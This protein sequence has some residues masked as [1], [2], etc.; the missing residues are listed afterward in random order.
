MQETETTGDELTAT[1]L[2][3]A[4]GF[5]GDQIEA[6]DPD[7][8]GELAGDQAQDFELEA[9]E[10]ASEALDPA[11]GATVEAL[12]QT[13]QSNGGA[14]SRATRGGRKQ[15]NRG[16]RPTRLTVRAA[17]RLGFE[18]GRGQN[19]ETAAREAGVGVSTAYRWLVAGRA[20]NPPFAELAVMVAVAKERRGAW[21]LN[22][23]SV[24]SIFGAGNA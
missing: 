10:L 21:R 12:D 24:R 22:M 1:E 16:G 2:N 4:G 3:Q 11:Q 7:Q 5:A 13:G 20:G 18:L 23:P 9:Q 15:R 17:L 19:L 14:T 8:A 6:L